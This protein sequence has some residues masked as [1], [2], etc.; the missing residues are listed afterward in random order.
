M[1]FLNK[2]IKFKHPEKYCAIKNCTGFRSYVKVQYPEDLI[3][4]EHYDLLLK[5][6]KTWKEMPYLELDEKIEKW[7][8]LKS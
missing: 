4:S 1:Q 2:L 5:E 3:C 8:S 7:I 6:A